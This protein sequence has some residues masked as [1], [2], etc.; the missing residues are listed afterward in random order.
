MKK[1]IKYFV[2]C[3]TLV[4]AFF[5]TDH[6]AQA[7][8][9]LKDSLEASEQLL[10]NHLG[11][12]QAA[13]TGGPVSNLQQTNATTTTVTITWNPAAG[14]TSYLIAESDGTSVWELETV[15]ATTYTRQYPAEDSYSILGVYPIDANGVAGTPET[16]LVSTVPTKIKTIAYA[17]YFASDRHLQVA[18]SQSLVADGY[19]VVC[20]NSKGKKV[21]KLDVSYAS[22]STS[23][24][25]FTKTNTRNTYYVVVT[26]YIYIN[27]GANKLYGAASG[28]FYAVP[29]PKVTSKNSDVKEHSVNLKWKKVTGATSYSV[30]VSTKKNSGYKKVAT[31]KTNSYK[32]TKYKGKTINTGKSTYYIKIVTNAKF[33]SKKVKSRDDYVISAYT[34]YY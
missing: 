11:E 25:T 18:W 16:V 23:G 22:Y 31:V 9:G 29:Q 1:S 10:Q 26:G 32:L 20:Y 24:I 34:T 30:Y 28:K 15:T 7:T 6:K 12:E 3:M 27:N 33:K 19:E 13:Y 17:D 21:Q 2:T 14:A 5:V 8:D 4:L